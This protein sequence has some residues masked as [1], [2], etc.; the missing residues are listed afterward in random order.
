MIN[1]ISRNFHNLKFKILSISLFYVFGFERNQTYI[2]DIMVNKICRNIFIVKRKM[3]IWSEYIGKVYFE[4]MICKYFN[5]IFLGFIYF[6]NDKKIKY[7]FRFNNFINID[8]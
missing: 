3:L 2:L 6:Q 5:L 1:S 4:N 7:I 8:F